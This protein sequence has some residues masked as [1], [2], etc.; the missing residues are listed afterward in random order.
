MM[1]GDSRIICQEM[2]YK[3]QEMSATGISWFVL[4]R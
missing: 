4:I 2:V 3:N 1:Q